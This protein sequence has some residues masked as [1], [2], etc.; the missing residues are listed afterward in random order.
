MIETHKLDTPINRATIEQLPIED[1]HDFIGRLQQRRLNSYN[2]YLAGLEAKK[3]KAA[4]SA[5]GGM[6]KALDN[7]IKTYQ[8]AEKNIEKL[9]KLAL[10]IQGYRLVLGDKVDLSDIEE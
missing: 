7:F 3:L 10:E 8:T 4:S 5:S 9:K 1:L 6:S 2:I